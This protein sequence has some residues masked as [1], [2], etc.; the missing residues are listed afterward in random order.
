MILTSLIFKVKALPELVSSRFIAESE[1]TG[2]LILELNVPESSDD[3]SLEL[4][5]HANEWDKLYTTELQFPAAYKATSRPKIL[6]FHPS[7][8]GK[9]NGRLLLQMV[10]LPEDGTHELRG[11]VIEDGETRALTCSVQY[12]RV[13]EI[14]RF[15]EISTDQISVPEG[16]KAEV[17]F[18]AGDLRFVVPFTVF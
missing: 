18:V 16:T 3:F 1:T 2:R 15:A 6:V 5:V 10:G 7:V 9:M 13:N 12:R 11:R 14:L 8:D 4:N 17:E